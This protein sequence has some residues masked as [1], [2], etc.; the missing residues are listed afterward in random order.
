LDNPDDFPADTVNLAKS[1]KE[2][3]KKS[4]GTYD[5][6]DSNNQQRLYRLIVE[7]EEGEHG[8]YA[9]HFNEVARA[10]ASQY[11]KK[12]CFYGQIG[13]IAK[14]NGVEEDQ[15]ARAIDDMKI[16]RCFFQ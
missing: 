9:Q 11:P 8:K 10:C 14:R 4:D 13:E 6:F 1:I 15:V 16:R 5:V 3:S 12:D 7:L 2:F